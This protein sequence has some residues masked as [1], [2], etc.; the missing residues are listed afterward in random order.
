MMAAVPKFWHKPGGC[1][2]YIR[3]YTL[4]AMY[5]YIICIQDVSVD[6]RY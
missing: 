6:T 4:Y 5:I 1:Y 3:M 2:V